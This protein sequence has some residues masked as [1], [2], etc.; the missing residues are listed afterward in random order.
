MFKLK[1]ISL[2]N[3]YSYPSSLTEQT[4]IFLCQKEIIGYVTRVII[5]VKEDMNNKVIIALTFL[6]LVSS[7]SEIDGTLSPISLTTVSTDET[8]PSNHDI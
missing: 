1:Y 4:N 6:F 8:Q 7:Q 2:K 5:F 3:K